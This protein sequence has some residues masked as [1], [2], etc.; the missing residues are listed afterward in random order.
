MSSDGQD[1]SEKA[2][3]Q[4]MKE[5]RRKGELARSQD[6]TAWIGLGAAALMLP[7]VISRAGQAATEQL[8]TVRDVALDPGARSVD[9]LLGDALRSFLPTMGTMFV[10]VVIVTVAVAAAQG[11]VH[12][13]QPKPTFKQLNVLA[14]IKRLVGAQTLWQGVKT[15]LKTAVVGLA[16]V[17]GVQALV[18]VL[19]GSGRLALSQLV[20]SASSG[21]VTLMRGGVGAGILLAVLDVVVVMRRNRKKTRMTLREVKD[22]NKRSEGDPLLKG[23]I[24]SKQMA[25]SRNRMMAAVADADVVLVNPT[26]VAVALRY[27]PGA[28]A[29]RVVAKGAGAVATRIRAEATAKHVPMVEDVP[30]A[31][32]LHSACEIGQEVPEYLFTAVARVLAF[33]MALRRRGAATGQ[34]RVPGAP[35]ELPEAPARR[36]RRRVPA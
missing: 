13:K 30:L 25:M 9:V 15:L 21:A 14:G 22:E 23:A 3:P 27:E 12:P 32:A 4:R 36:R 8:Q 34:H 11:G 28:G 31:R 24:R 29:P 16:L 17:A 33:V 18:P 26:H 10:V 5:V 7:G 20:D 2:T 6:L 19:V 1:R 35:V